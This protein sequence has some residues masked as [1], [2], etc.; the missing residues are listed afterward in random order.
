MF[1]KE[2]ETLGHESFSCCRVEELWNERHKWRQYNIETDKDAPSSYEIGYGR[3]AL[4]YYV[5]WK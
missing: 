2:M 5:L 4:Q 3:C 1:Q